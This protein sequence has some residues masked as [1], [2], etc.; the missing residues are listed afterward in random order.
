MRHGV[1]AAE[2][3]RIKVQVPEYL[4]AAVGKDHMPQTSNEARFHL[5]YCL[6][7]AAND[8]DFISR[9]IRS[10]SN[11]EIAALVDRLEVSSLDISGTIHAKPY[12]ISRVTIEGPDGEI[13]ESGCFAEMP[14]GGVIVRTSYGTAQHRSCVCFER[15]WGW[16]AYVDHAGTS[17][18][19]QG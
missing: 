11:P 2:A 10:N 18:R 7:H 4:L 17:S 12:N 15:S 8:A 13:V 1:N 14:P 3:K 6:A 19:R 5:Q 9:P 16:R